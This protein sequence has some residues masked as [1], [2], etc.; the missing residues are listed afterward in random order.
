MLNIDPTI[1]AALA[2]E[3]VLSSQAVEIQIAPTADI[4]TNGALPVVKYVVIPKSVQ[5]KDG[6]IQIIP[7]CTRAIIDAKGT[8]SELSEDES[9]D[10]S[11][12]SNHA[13]CI[14]CGEDLTEDEQVLY[15][16]LC[17]LCNSTSK[18]RG[19]DE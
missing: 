7:L 11:A 4:F 10:V 15:K 18:E 9:D 16:N 2:L 3:A 5:V 6:S 8:L 1:K 12:I 13:S 19:R 14:K 17:G